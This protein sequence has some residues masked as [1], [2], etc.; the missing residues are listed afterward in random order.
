MHGRQDNDNMKGKKRRREGTKV[1]VY[2]NT[3]K[4]CI[5][6]TENNEGH[7]ITAKRSNSVWWF[8]HVGNECGYL[9]I[10][11]ANQ[12][13]QD[14]PPFASEMALRPPPLAP[15]MEYGSGPMMPPAPPPQYFQ[16]SVRYLYLSPYYI[17]VRRYFNQNFRLYL[18]LFQ[19]SINI[20]SVGCALPAATTKILLFYNV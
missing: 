18:K 1:C 12:A 2:Y 10:K 11:E 16:Q 15:P 3:S 19:F 5:H 13:F 7:K 20:S 8:G 9:H 14:R 6:G 17:D 4:G